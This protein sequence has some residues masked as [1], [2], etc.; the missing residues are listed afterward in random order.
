VWIQKNP[1]FGY[2][3]LLARGAT[4]WRNVNHFVI[5]ASTMEVEFVACFKAIIQD[6]W[7]HKFILR[8]GIVNVARPQK[9]YCDNSKTMFFSEQQVL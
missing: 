9:I 4:S 2:V 1:L 8:L 7:L 6:N 3:F 5:S